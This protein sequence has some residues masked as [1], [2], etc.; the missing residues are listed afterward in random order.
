MKAPKRRLASL[1]TAAPDLVGAV[2]D[3]VKTHKKIVKEVVWKDSNKLVGI[4]FKKGRDLNTTE[5][6][7]IAKSDLVNNFSVS[8]SADERNELLLVA[9]I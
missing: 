7:S 3:F 4:R 9:W 5:L 6:L 8:L 1:E 2:E